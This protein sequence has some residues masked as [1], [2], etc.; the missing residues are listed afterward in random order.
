LPRL[1]RAGVEFVEGDVR[2]PEDLGRLPKVSAILECSA[3]PSA[4]SGADGDT[5]YVVETSLTGAYNCLELARRYGAAMVFLSTSRVYPLEA[6]R[7][8][9]YAEGATRFEL[10]A[11][12]ALPG[13]T[14]A[15]VSEDF[16]LEGAR[17]LYGATKLAAAL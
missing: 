3:E 13:V 12:Q 6:L 7:G 4:M 8:I 9:L 1:E 17:T 10:S 16:P 11:E 2:R 5:S 14:P 15:G